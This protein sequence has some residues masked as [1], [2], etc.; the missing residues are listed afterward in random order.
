MA[1]LLVLVA[2]LISALRLLL[3]YVEHYREDFQNY[4]NQQ[5]QTNIVIGGLGM[6]WQRWGPTVIAKQVTLVDNHDATIYIDEIEIEI[7]FLSSLKQQQLVSS[8]LTLEGLKL[9]LFKSLWLK[10]EGKKETETQDNLAKDVSAFEQ[11]SSIFLNRLKQ[12]SVLDS[13]I[14]IQNEKLNRHFYVSN[15]YW[16]NNGDRH[17]AQ[18]SVIVNEL[19]SNNISLQIDIEGES[20][21]ELTGQMYLEANHLDIT[22]WLDNVLAIDNDKTVAD[23]GFYAWLKINN[24]DIERLQIDLHDNYI[25]WQGSDG[26]Q[27]LALSSGQLLLVDGKEADSFKLFST[28]LLMRFNQQDELEYTVQV[29]KG[30]DDYAL[31]LSAVDLAMFSQISP[32]FI[33]DENTRQLLI[34]MD[35]AG[36][37]ND[38]YIKY[39]PETLQ[40]VASFSNTSTK[41]S[42]GIPGFDNLSGEL[43]LAQNNL[44]LEILAEQGALDFQQHFVAPIVYEKVKAS[45]DLS[46]GE[47]SFERKGWQL[48]VNDI[49]FTSPELS[50]TADLAVDAFEGLEPSMSLLASITRG[51]ASKAGHYFPLTTMSANLVSYLNE[52]IISGTMVQ[53]QVLI[54]GPL[55]HFPFNDNSGIFV[56]DAELEE[57]Q[58][59]FEKNWPVI[60]EFAANLNFTNNSM[61]ITGRAGSLVGLDVDGVQAAI[62]DL[63]H[64]QLLSVDTIIK[65]SS[66]ELVA[67]LIDQSPLKESVGE[68]LQALQVSGN[69]NGEFHLNL[70]LN[71]TDKAVAS[72]LINFSNNHVALQTPRMD[73]ERV[74]GQL[75]FKNDELSTTDLSLTWLDLPLAL[76]I[77][78]INKDSYYDTNIALSAN[79]QEVQWQAHISPLLKKYFGAQLQWQG[80]LSLYEHHNG[81]FSYTLAIES[82]LAQSEF[83]LPTPYHKTIGEKRPLIAEVTGQLD[84]S[85]INV[86]YGEQ[87]SFYGVLKHQGSHFERAHLVLGDEKMLL[88]MA[89]FHITTKLEHAEFE[90]W[91]PLI[92]DI[93]DTVQ[94]ETSTGSDDV[95]LAG[96]HSL[97]SK[98]ERIRGTLTQLDVLGQQL[99]NVSFNLLDQTHWWLLQLN[100][101]ETRSRIKFYPDWFAQGVDVNADFIHFSVKDETVVKEELQEITSKSKTDQQSVFA[102]IPKLT[103]HC[104]RCQIDELDLGEVS[105]ALSRKEEDVIS[106]DHFTAKREQAEF[107]LF[108]QWKYNEQESVTDIQGDL[109]LKDIEYELEQLGYGSIIKDSGGTLDYQLAWQGG[110]H[111]FVFE[112]LNGDVKVNIDD[113]YLAEVSDKAKLFSVLSLD[114]I[115][116]KLTLDFRDIFSDGMFYSDIKGD[117]Q[118]KNG[119]LYTDNTRMNGTAGNLYIQGN[120]DFVTNLLDYKMSY[121]PNLT[122]SLPVLAWIAMSNPVGFLAGIALDQVITS[123]VVSEF[124]FEFTG[125]VDDPTFKEVNRKT[126]NVSVGRSTPPEFV[127]NA[128]E[129]NPTKIDNKQ[130]EPL[131]PEKT[132]ENPINKIDELNNG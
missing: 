25:A 3:P 2:V 112:Q 17:Q 84:Q 61:L 128:T 64:E 22:P 13:H 111:E 78:G 74:N 46:F 55:S 23:V 31:Y 87:L 19:S 4:I 81:D 116:R 132:I 72:G 115:V 58:F 108:G 130:P 131:Q 70:P 24:G 76:E 97:F 6:S 59:Q 66:A 98:P 121:K 107:K 73:F 114:S 103:L 101:K 30:N 79:W 40:A 18:G 88:P 92:S 91:Q 20:V 77:K 124:N 100:A 106:I 120:T 123:K 82:D 49:D 12:F 67:K 50:L 5:N 34:D 105:I 104:D 37:A 68:V 44:H 29:N 129:S 43:S 41:Y 93:I 62:D 54:N 127:D 75:A 10:G 53:G 52:A 51:D 83:N 86:S 48:Q 126:R 27:S 32:L 113:G 33:G 7:D 63:G 42:Q 39:T 96:S 35:I 119:I 69:I 71:A 122:S 89:G 85:T 94:Q 45:A 38:V 99:N 14:V 95:E 15:L 26:Q 9:E 80:D 47:L 56:V 57:A 60:E 21:D 90:Q 117:Y 102:N 109:A 36:Q 8:N 1:I 118:I 110:P 125:S 11:I 28:P 16:K 65:P